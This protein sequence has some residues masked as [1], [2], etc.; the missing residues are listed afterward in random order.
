MN[1]IDLVINRLRDHGCNPRENGTG[2]WKSRCP[3]HDGKSS[4]LSVTEDED[5]KVLLHCHHAENGSETC[6]AA[7]IV[8]ALG[9]EMRDLFPPKP[10]Q[11][12]KPS[13]P[14]RNGKLWRSPEDAIGWVVKQVKG[15][16]SR[17]GPWIYN[18]RDSSEFFRV[19]RIDLPDGEKQFRPIYPDPIKNGWHIGDPCKD[20]LPLY[21]LDELAAAE[22]VYVLEG[23][24]CADL[25]RGLGVTATTS[26][27][28]S[29]GAAKS[30]WTSLVGKTVRLIP[31]HDKVGEGY[32]N[33]V[34]A[35]LKGLGVRAR[36]IR[37]PVTGDGHDAR[38]W[39]DEIV[40]DSWG[41]DE[42]R[43]ELER[44]AAAAAEWG[45]SPTTK[46]VT[47]PT[48][49]LTCLSD[50]EEKDVEWLWL[51]RIPLGVLTSFCGDPKLG[52]SFTTLAITAA[53]SRGAV[54]PDGIAPDRPGSVILLSAEDD[55]ART[56][57]PRL[58]AAGAILSRIHI[59]ESI[60]V[61]ESREGA[62]PL[63]RMPSLLAHDLDVIEAAASQIADLKLIVIDPV[64]AYL[65]GTDDHR[66]TELRSVLS[67]LKALAERLNIAIILVSHLAKGGGTNGKY[68][69]IGS[70]AYI[71]A[72]R[73]NFL[74]A[75]DKDDPAGRRVLM[76]DNGC[77]IA[78]NQPAVAFTIEDRG[79]GP[80]L[81]WLAETIDKDADTYL[82]EMAEAAAEKARDA[83]RAT[84]SRQCEDW[85]RK[86]LNSGPVAAKDVYRQASEA[87]YSVDQAK[88]AKVRIGA[89]ARKDGFTDDSRWL[90]QFSPEG[91]GD[92]KAF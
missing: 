19:Y 39:L 82:A 63:E 28:G 7:A 43:V 52:K 8:G 18:D 83:T 51:N 68:R 17:L 34:G 78:P 69:M 67:P 25:V 45:A 58:R 55:P 14:E 66:N 77:N 2:Q 80:A 65:A 79:D 30:D 44:L 88:R 71:A 4:N 10:D 90:W 84:M 50:I 6:S 36:V 3:A 41:P 73:A 32:I 27:H 76:L 1:P 47:A 75:R 92:A 56:I 15:Q 62:P 23:E 57:K 38:E 74:F 72:C 54:L 48:A 35:I 87:G 89:I 86:L 81:E 46:P 26:S 60:I 61:P 42:C 37:L 12:S 31:D 64:S 91:S 33:D 13:K 85:L 16:L 53:V 22:V 9:L 24:K 70:I 21:H 11:P 49:K 59:L 29:S 20:G 5:G 40:P